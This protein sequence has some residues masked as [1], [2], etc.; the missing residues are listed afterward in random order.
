MT[1]TLKKADLGDCAAIHALQIS[2]FTE[3][4]EKYR[5]TATN[6]G[7]EPLERIVL[8]MAQPNTDY[9]FIRLDE[10]TIG[11]IRVVRLDDT[12]CRISP[13]FL[14]PE[15]WNKGYAQQA[16]HFTESL[17]P[18]ARLWELDTIKQEPKLCHLYEKLGYRQTGKEED[19]QPGMTIV[20]YEK[21]V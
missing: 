16:I 14:L 1:V 18:N 19:I 6:P 12:A 7:A 10:Q 11:A 21:R 4:L 20:F 9:Y 5:D 17:Y 3:L 13:M 15:Y 8:R 2:A